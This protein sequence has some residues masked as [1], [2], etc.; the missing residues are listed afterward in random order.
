MN[1]ERYVIGAIL[2]D[3]DALDEIS[4]TVDDFTGPYAKV[5]AA[6]Q[7]LRSTSEPLDIV[8]VCRTAGNETAQTV[9]ACVDE[10]PT[11]ANIGYYAKLVREDSDRRRLLE[12]ALG[13]S[14]KIETEKPSVA[15]AWCEGEL[16]RMAE[17]K[18]SGSVVAGQVVKAVVKDI[19]EA[20]VRGGQ[21]NGLSTGYRKLDY[22]TCG[23]QPADLI[24]IGARPSVGK[25]ALAM[26]L[27][28]NISVVF[29]KPGLVISRE[30]SSEALI[31]R[32]TCSRAEVDTMAARR[33]T[34]KQS[35]FPRLAQS[36]GEIANSAL[37]INDDELNIYDI[38][39]ESRRAKRK[40]KIEYV[41]VDYLQLVKA[42]GCESRRVEV[43]EVSGQL[44][45][46]AKELKIPVIALCQ[47]NRGKEG[48][49]RAPRLDDLKESGDI[50]QDADV[51]LLLDR[52]KE[53]DNEE[54]KLYLAKQRNGPLGIVNM[55]YDGPTVRFTEIQY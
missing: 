35:D 49:K 46:M 4:L 25:T 41:I 20:A 45:A 50:E 16:Y 13:L 31:H 27:A 40:H 51:V 55:N 30:M 11:A 12:M 38:R 22:M 3:P 26:N 36:A 32:M 33:G 14:G 53:H 9:S 24:I 52:A 19:E 44:K 34:V 48:E 37:I 29:G 2:L 39:A 28:D 21:I 17:S 7:K 5:F 15:R 6:M 42:P 23:L 10:V 8:S 54:A 43:G 1:A 47:L 18:S